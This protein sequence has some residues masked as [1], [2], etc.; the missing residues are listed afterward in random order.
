MPGKRRRGFLGRL[1]RME[2]TRVHQV[3]AR[4]K[5]VPPEVPMAPQVL[6]AGAGLEPATYGL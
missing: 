1:I 3:L 5:A 6:V 4:E 2:G